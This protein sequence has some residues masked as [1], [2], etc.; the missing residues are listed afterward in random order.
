[1]ASASSREGQAMIEFVIALVGILIVTAGMLL[2]AELNRAD[3]ETL[4]LATGKAIS[5]A[6]SLSI[7]SSFTPVQ[8]WEEGTDG[9]RYTKD[10]Q[11]DEGS[12]SG[13]RA[14]ITGY[15]APNGDWWG[16][17]RADGSSVYYDDIVQLHKGVLVASTFRFNRVEEEQDVA[18]LPVLQSLM[19]LPATLTI[20][21]EVWMPSLGGLYIKP[22]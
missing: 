1:M 14:N 7:A 15:T 16:T 2:L 8:D 22:Y 9:M 3:T 4:T 6:M 12:F 13:V 5:K 10:D 20:R 11:P 21:N 19:G 18:T 17:R